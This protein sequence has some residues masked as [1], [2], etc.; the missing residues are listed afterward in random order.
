MSTDKRLIAAIALSIFVI[1]MFQII[2]PQPRRKKVV[3]QDPVAE[4]QVMSEPFRELTPTELTQ[5]VVTE[6]RET[7]EENGFNPYLS[8]S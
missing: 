2:F 4:Q 5:K 6:A 1:V 7:D 3:S 8:I